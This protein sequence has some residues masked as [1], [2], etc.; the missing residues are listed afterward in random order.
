[1]ASQCSFFSP[2]RIFRKR[3]KLLG[4]E[5]YYEGGETLN[6][7]RKELIFFALI[8]YTRHKWRHMLDRKMPEMVH[9]SSDITFAA[10]VLE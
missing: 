5:W 2:H 8:V 3:T 10:V 7:F 6:L 1:M 4:I 9:D